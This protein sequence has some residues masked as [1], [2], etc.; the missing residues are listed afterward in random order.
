MTKFLAAFGMIILSTTLSF[1]RKPVGESEAPEF[2]GPEVVKAGELNYP[3]RSVAYGIVV[4]EVT[5]DA[6]GEVEAANVVRDIVS[7][8]PEAIRAVKGWQFRPAK[9]EGKPIE[10]RTTVVVVFNPALNNPPDATLPP[11]ANHEQKQSQPFSPPRVIEAVYPKYPIWSA[12][13]GTVVLKLEI[14]AEGRAQGMEIL[15]DI[16]SL[17]PEAVQA[18]KGWKFEPATL[19]GRQVSS[20]MAVAFVFRQPVHTNSR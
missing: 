1:V 7:L 5:V 18:V 8:T 20:K 3:V 19:D 4:L 2:Q 14:D 17:T 6:S 11:L 16:A 10:S 13:W 12:A 15:R 9:L